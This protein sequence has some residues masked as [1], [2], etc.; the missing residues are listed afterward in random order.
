MESLQQYEKKSY[1]LYKDKTSSKA[2]AIFNYGCT[3]FDCN[4][5]DK[6]VEY[7]NKGLSC[8]SKG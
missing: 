7:I 8:I 5:K 4:M 1:E 2:M 6:A 3:M